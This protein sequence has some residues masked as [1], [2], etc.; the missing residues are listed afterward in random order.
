MSAVEM[1]PTA[2]ER[3]TVER[4]AAGQGLVAVCALEAVRR[5][6]GVCALVAGEAVAVFRT[7]DDRVFALGNLDPA[8][9]ASVLSR[10]IVGDRTV[11]GAVVPFVASPLLKHPYSLLDGV[12]LDDATLRV[13][14]YEVRVADGLV[15]VGSRRGG[16]T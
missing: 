2:A 16:L 10:G 6:A 12:C 13:P 9:G 3:A 5:E 8:T 1:E 11:D 4:G 14:T 15:W 7:H